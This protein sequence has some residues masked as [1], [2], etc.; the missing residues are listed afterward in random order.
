[1]LKYIHK[2]GL[3]VLLQHRVVRQN[4]GERNYHVFYQLV[5]GITEEEKG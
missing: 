2:P 1:M 4:P 3:C 5:R